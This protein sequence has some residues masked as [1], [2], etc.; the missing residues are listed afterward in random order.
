MKGWK[1]Y[2]QEVVSASELL[3]T[4]S[5]WHEAGQI[6]ARNERTQDNYS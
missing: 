1:S 3:T 4:S 5:I 2:L 6:I